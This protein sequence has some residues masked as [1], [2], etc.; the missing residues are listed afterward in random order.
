MKNKKKI[1]FMVIALVVAI[2]LIISG[3]LI[4]KKNKAKQSN[5]ANQNINVIKAIT[6]EDYK[7]LSDANGLYLIGNNESVKFLNNQGEV[8]FE[9]NELK[10][11]SNQLIV[12][13]NE[14]ATLVKDDIYRIYDKDFNLIIES[15]DKL[16]LL[17]DNVAKVSYYVKEN[18]LYNLNNEIVYES[19]F[20]DKNSSYIEMYGDYVS[21][22]NQLVN[23]KTKEKYNYKFETILGDKTVFYTQNNENN[24]GKN[25]YVIDGNDN[26]FEKYNFYEIFSYGVLVYNDVN[27]D[28]KLITDSQV[29]NYG[30]DLEFRGYK[31]DYKV[32]DDGFKVYSR[33]GKLIEDTCYAAYYVFEG[34]DYIALSKSEDDNSE[35]GY[36]STYYLVD[37]KILNYAPM[38]KYF[39]D[40]ST[41]AEIKVY[42]ENGEKVEHSCS[43]YISYYQDN[44]YVCSNGASVYLMDESFNKISDTYKQL[45]CGDGKCTTSKDG[46]Q[47]LIIGN[48]VILEPL[49]ESIS[50]PSEN[51]VIVDEAY[52]CKFL[53]L[54]EGE[55]LSKEELSK[56]MEPNINVDINSIII[57]NEL[58]DMLGLIND[59]SE[60]FKKYAYF[61]EKNKQL[62]QYKKYVYESFPVVAKNKE[63]LDESY[64]FPALRNLYIVDKTDEKNKTANGY[65]YDET[66]KIEILENWDSVIYHELM[67]FIDFRINQDDSLIIYSY[68]DKFLNEDEYY[69]LTLEEQNKAEFLGGLNANF[70]TEGGAEINTAMYLED[71]IVTTYSTQINVYSILSY[72][73]GNEFMNEVYFSKNG[74]LK[75]FEKFVEAGYGY[76][77]YKDFTSKT[78]FYYE[79]NSEKSTVE[80]YDILIGLYEA[81]NNDKWYEDKVMSALVKNGMGY[82]ELKPSYTSRYD[83]YKSI[84]FDFEKIRDQ[85]NEK[86]GDKYYTNICP[87]FMIY[88]NDLYITFSVFSWDPASN[89][90]KRKYFVAK[91]DV[92]TG[93]VIDYKYVEA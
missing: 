35:L 9:L 7:Y 50:S 68:G 88:N 73:Y 45:Y 21:D 83:E 25:V 64:F 8:V 44:M 17:F 59:N 46:K 54:G 81:Q 48:D 13:H 76:D 38:G 91:Y 93:N 23:I 82:Y 51:I 77:E 36:Q 30:D 24:K 15:K 39:L 16:T 32:C 1:I 10:T 78:S 14:T 62:G 69:E 27:G 40:T 22:S 52:G 55:A 74:E 20:K 65:Y 80:F 92:D 43:L 79:S 63:Y 6:Y 29:I 85:F 90:D 53:I 70:L 11:S 42:D 72:L 12:S 71:N 75:L 49:Y 33:E 87:S 3:V 47:G 57:D 41:Q 66:L 28:K 58:D 18:N 5:Q 56:R 67:H 26:S 31:F 60:L 37:D 89:N 84:K 4:L 19:L 34:E 61:V 86:Y 2:L